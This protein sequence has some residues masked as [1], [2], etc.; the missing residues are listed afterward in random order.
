MRRSPL[1][2]LG[3]LSAVALSTAVSGGPAG[4]KVVERGEFHD[5]FI[6][7]VDD[8]CDIAGFHLDV[9]TNVDG[10][11]TLTSRGRDQLIYYAEHTVI[12]RTLT[13]P[14]SELSAS[15]KTRIL[16]K[17]LH[18]RDNGDG[19]LTIIILATGPS[20][21]YGPDG[22]AIARDPGQVRFELVVDH[23]GTP[24]DPSD[25]TEISFTQIK[26]STGRTD[27]YCEALFAAIG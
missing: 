9:T 10:R 24:T 13:N 12:T 23:G 14:D 22:K 1:L 21:L 26:G 27:D 7:S 2:A 17:D 20:S 5:V 15:E 3:V 16:D 18:V 8:F 4:A 25:D 11:Y 6:E 19:T